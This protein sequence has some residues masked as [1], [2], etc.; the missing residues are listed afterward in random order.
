MKIIQ[1]RVRSSSSRS[2]IDVEDSGTHKHYTYNSFL[3]PLEIGAEN[4]Q[5]YHGYEGRMRIC[6]L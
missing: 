5:H 2:E 6:D 1:V 4:R 3:F